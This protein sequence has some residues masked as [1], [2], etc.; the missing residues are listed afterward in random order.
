MRKVPRLEASCGIPQHTHRSV[1]LLP[2]LSKRL[3][4]AVLQ[5]TWKG[6]ALSPSARCDGR[7][8]RLD[9]QHQERRSM[10]RLPRGIPRLGDALGPLTRLREGR[11]REF[12]GPEPIPGRCIGR[13][14]EVRARVCQLPRSAYDPPAARCDSTG[15]SARFRVQLSGWRDLNSRLRDPRSRALPGCATP[16]NSPHS[17][18]WG[19]ANE[20][21]HQACPLV[22]G[23]PPRPGDQ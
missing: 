22:R 2:G 10:R 17:R 18:T 12:D 8:S 11:G 14:Q 23:W 7:S 16:R 6:Y 1:L 9:G 4:P 19:H 5:R 20:V 21:V 3:R 15:W 13:G